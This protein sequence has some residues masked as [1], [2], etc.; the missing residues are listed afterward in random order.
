MKLKLTTKSQIEKRPAW[1]EA[2][3]RTKAEVPTSSPNNAKPNVTSLC[4]LRGVLQVGQLS[5]Q[6][7]LQRTKTDLIFCYE[8]KYFVQPEYKK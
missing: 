6:K 2:Q 7:L 8:F 5:N 3:Q 4:H 1:T